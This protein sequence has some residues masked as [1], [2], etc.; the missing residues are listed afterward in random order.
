MSYTNYLYIWI[1]SKKYD[2]AP[3]KC[4]C[5]CTLCIMGRMLYF[6]EYNICSILYC[7]HLKS[8]TFFC[9]GSS[10][11]LTTN[12]QAVIEQSFI[13]QTISESWNWRTIWYW[14]TMIVN[15]QWC[16]HQKIWLSFPCPSFAASIQEWTSSDFGGP[17]F[18]LLFLVDYVFVY[19]FSSQIQIIYVV[20]W[21][22]NIT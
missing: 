5:T 13:C 22:V 21:S 3:M 18:K 14:Y 8:P 11:S 6:T 7:T 16:F 1:S 12:R 15:N 9:L 4:L 2:V 17:S 10:F 20:V 19:L